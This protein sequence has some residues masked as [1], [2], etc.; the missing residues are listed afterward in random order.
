MKKAVLFA[1]CC[2]IALGASAQVRKCIGADGKV[3]Y[4][5]FV[6]GAGT[7]KEAGVTT[8][9]NTLDGSGMRQES[10]RQ[11]DIAEEDA[12]ILSKPA[13]CNFRSYKYGDSKGKVLADAAK[14]E[15]MQNLLTKNQGQ[16]SSEA[17]Y[18]KWLDHHT[19]EAMKRKPT[20][21][22][23]NCQPNGFGGMR[24]S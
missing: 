14:Q 16:A 12:I 17:S 13:E 23:M 15:C 11:K 9:A 7:A 19:L 1:A 6:C 4:S 8:N 2:A 10:K 21:N 20:N 24:C 5:D 18:K 22:T 3:T